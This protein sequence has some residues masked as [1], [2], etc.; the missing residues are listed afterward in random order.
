MD[1][2]FG[3]PD[4]LGVEGLRSDIAT[5]IANGISKIARHAA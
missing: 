5:T 2:A 1:L 4:V 3:Y